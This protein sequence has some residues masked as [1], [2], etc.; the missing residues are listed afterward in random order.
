MA[1]AAVWR[2]SLALVVKSEVQQTLQQAVPLQHSS[3]PSL[4]N[5]AAGRLYSA[6]RYTWAVGHV[7][8]PILMCMHAPNLKRIKTH[9]SS[10]RFIC[11]Y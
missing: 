6:V 4:S 11:H 2:A 1:V 9:S 7:Y 3:R 10:R 8:A 5:T